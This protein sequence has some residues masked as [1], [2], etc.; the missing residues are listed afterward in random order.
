MAKDDNVLAKKSTDKLNKSLKGID[1]KLLK[2]ND[3]HIAWMECLVE[4]KRTSKVMAGS[5][6]ITVQREQFIA[7][8]AIM[9]KSIE[10]F[11][12]NKKVYKQFCP[13]ANNDKG[14]FWLSDKEEIRNPFF[15]EMML[16]CGNV[17]KV[18][19]GY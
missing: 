18:I 11:G 4:I 15:G 9:I 13:M 10:T 14:V 2:S 19:D 17:D 3:S 12:I 16:K 6:D 1:M 7:L 8:S 5:L